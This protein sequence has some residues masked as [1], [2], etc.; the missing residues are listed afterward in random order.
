MTGVQAEGLAPDV[1]ADILRSAIE[2]RIDHDVLQEVLAE[3]QRIRG[4]LGTL[5][6]IS[7]TKK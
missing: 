1:M 7:F 3:E 4:E 2:D 6:A 5:A